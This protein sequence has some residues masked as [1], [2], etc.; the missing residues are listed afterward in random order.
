MDDLER[1]FSHVKKTSTCWNWTAYLYPNG[2]GLFGTGTRKTVKKYY[3]HRFIYEYLYNP[4]PKGFQLHHI[5]KNRKCVN[6]DHLMMVL[7]AEHAKLDLPETCFH[8]HKFTSKN[9]YVCK[10]GWRHCRECRRIAD[11]KRRPPTTEWGKARCNRL[12]LI[13]IVKGV[14]NA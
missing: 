3:A 13:E 8:G 7:P 9:T 14:G 11:R 10:N 5:C 4:I 6:P 12:E 1:F 2:Y